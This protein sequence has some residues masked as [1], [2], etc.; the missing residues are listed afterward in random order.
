MH[1]LMPRLQL[2]EVELTGAQD[3]TDPMRDVAVAVTF[4]GPNGARETVAAFHDGGRTWRARFS[5][6]TPGAWQY[7]AEATRSED[8]G[9]NGQH[10][11]VDVPPYQGDAPLLRHGPIRRA[12][13]GLSLA[14]ADG[15]P[16][17]WLGDTAW[18]GVLKA[19]PDEWEQYLAVRREQGFTAVQ[20]VLTQWR[21][22]PHDAAGEMAFQGRESIVIN[23]AFYQ[24]LDDKVGAIAAHGLVPALVLIWANTPK[25]PGY[26]LPAEDMI[27]LA[28]YEVA[29]YAAYRPVWLLGGDGEYRGAAGE[30]WKATGRA[31]FG[32]SGEQPVTMHP[33]GIN[34]PGEDLRDEPWLTF[35]AYQSGHGDGD[36]DLRWLQSGP[37]AATWMT[38]PLKPVI[39]QEPNYEAHL[40]YQK[41]QVFNDYHVRRASY[42]S[43]LV[44]PTAGVTYGHHGIW[45]WMEERGVPADHD[46]SGQ[47]PVWHEALHADGAEQMRFLRQFF[48]GLAWWHLRPAVHLLRAQ[49][50]DADPNRFI[51]IAATAQGTEVVAYVPM[52]DALH[53]TVPLENARWFNPRSG[54]WRAAGAGERFEPP[55]GRDWVL[56]GETRTAVM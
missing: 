23:P 56:R 14:H 49:P 37:P 26:Y 7:A 48:D 50:G 41:R 51:A 54:G 29:R 18:N 46:K 47:A 24:R 35:H 40:S 12:Q 53:L 42:W 36:R 34:W 5:P 2:I 13:D 8:A 20:A 45:P 11:L 43:L 31:V 22:F 19:R 1:V 32:E 25:D 30:K 39:N 17:F 52:G 28:R 3:Y 33:G 10:G 9:L 6:P 44:T 55:D 27:L 16:F 38:Q 15:T 21:S 4:S